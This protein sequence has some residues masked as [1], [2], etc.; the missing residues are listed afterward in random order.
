MYTFPAGVKALIMSVSV[1]SELY[2]SAITAFVSYDR[3]AFV[4]LKSPS[5]CADVSHLMSLNRR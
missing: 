4:V 5:R 3:W 2:Y 1:K